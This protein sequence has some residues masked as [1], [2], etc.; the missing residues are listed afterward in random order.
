M[1]KLFG[2]ICLAAITL[3]GC[4]QK[5]TVSSPD[6]VL[7]VSFRLGADG[8]PEYKVARKGA[9][10]LDWSALGLVLADKDLSRDFTLLGTDTDSFDETWETVRAR[11][12]I[13]AITIVNSR[14]TSCTNQAQRWMS[15]S[16]FSTMD[17]RS[18]MSFRPMPTA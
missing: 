8:A 17:L 2:C 9:P 4:Q 7:A 1:K 3:T 15:S 12:V 10:M 11:N 16:V 14:H 5:M 6:N 13:S 18:D